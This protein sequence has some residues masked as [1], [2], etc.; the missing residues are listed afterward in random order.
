MAQSEQL[1]EPLGLA[2]VEC[3]PSAPSL[4]WISSGELLP[5]LR[6]VAVLLFYQTAEGLRR[7]LSASRPVT[8]QSIGLIFADSLHTGHLILPDAMSF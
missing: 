6:P 3:L 1:L 7:M 5:W 2:A 8:P 4:V